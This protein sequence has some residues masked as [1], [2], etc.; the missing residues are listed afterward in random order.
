MKVEE[1]LNVTF[2]KTPPPSKTSPLE[3]D[4][5]VK[6]EARPDIM[7]SV[8]LCARFQENPKTSHLEAIKCIFRY[9]KGTIHLGLWYPKGSGIETIVYADSDNVGDYVD[10]KSTS[11]IY[12]FMGCCLTS[13]FS[14]KQTALAISTTEV[15]YVSVK[16]ACQ[17]A[18]LIKQALVDYGSRLDDI[19]ITKG[20]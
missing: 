1:S 17:Q 19:P 11:G 7:F 10:R 14:K 13:W 9:S 6:E 8:C 2:D 18:L 20:L 12:M 5:L 3:D 4:D 16:K 15:K